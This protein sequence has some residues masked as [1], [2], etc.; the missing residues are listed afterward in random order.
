MTSTSQPDHA[1]ET[2]QDQDWGEQLFLA[3]L[4]FADNPE[5]RCPCVLLLDTSQSM[6]GERITALNDG[7]QGFRQELLK[8][9]LARQRV[10]DTIMTFGGRPGDERPVETL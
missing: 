9:L 2:K 8:D 3:G 1:A 4:E 7:L 10:E 6:A 5:P